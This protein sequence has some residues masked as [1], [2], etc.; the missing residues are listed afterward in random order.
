[1][2]GKGAARCP[3]G[4]KAPAARGGE[5]AV[6]CGWLPTLAAPPGSTREGISLARLYQ[7]LTHRSGSLLREMERVT[8]QG[9]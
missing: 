6:G 9:G 5:S 1:V 4:S 8:L 7:R 2:R 3:K